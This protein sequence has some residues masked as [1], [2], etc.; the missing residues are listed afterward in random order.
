[1]G[2][3]SIMAKTFLAQSR[4]SDA[5]TL[6]GAATALFLSLDQY[7]NFYS[8]QVIGDDKNSFLSS[9]MSLRT[10]FVPNAAA[11]FIGT[12]LDTTM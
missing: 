8:F 1:M 12:T 4:L 9:A 5:P 7:D 3:P 11:C 2:K 10:S 6:V